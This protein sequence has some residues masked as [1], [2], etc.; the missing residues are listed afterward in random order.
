[1]NG[2]V[3]CRKRAGLTTIEVGEKLNISSSTITKWET[4]G[5]MPRKDTLKRLTALYKCTMDELL[6]EG[7]GDDA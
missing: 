3:M 2:F 1:M 5:H 6:R 4:S 7:D